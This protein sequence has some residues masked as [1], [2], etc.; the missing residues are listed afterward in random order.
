MSEAP[1][2]AASIHPAV[3]VTIR[4]TFVQP[5]AAINVH[6]ENRHA[7]G[8]S[9]ERVRAHAVVLDVQACWAFSSLVPK[10]GR[11]A[12]HCRPAAPPRPAPRQRLAG[13]AAAAEKVTDRCGLKAVRLGLRGF[14]RRR[15]RPRGYR[16]GCDIRQVAA[17]IMRRPRCV[18][19][20]A[21]SSDHS[22]PPVLGGFSENH[23]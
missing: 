1:K 2:W 14:S 19:A 10:C 21:S 8:R 20:G 5:T 18:R 12:V 23:L 11:L 4:A 22:R 17:R 9:S 13:A 6:L 16:R 3:P 7:E 15:K